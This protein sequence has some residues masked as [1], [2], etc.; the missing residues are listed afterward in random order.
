ML[1]RFALRVAGGTVLGLAVVAA[2]VGLVSVFDGNAAPPGELL[3]QVLVLSPLITTLA[4][5]LGV[6]GLR[7]RG[8]LVV[9]AL[10][11]RHPA[12]WSVAAGLGAVLVVAVLTGLQV[13]VPTAENAAVQVAVEADA[14]W[15]RSA[16]GQQVVRLGVQPAWTDAGE[17]RFGEPPSQEPHWRPLRTAA[18]PGDSLVTLLWGTGSP[19]RLAW[20]LL[21]GMLPLLAGGSALLGALAETMAVRGRSLG[22]LAAAGTI[23]L[24]VVAATVLGARGMLPVGV[25]L[26]PAALLAPCCAVLWRRDARYSATM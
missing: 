18:G 2:V 5:G 22:A 26:V 9:L 15:W 11:G 25:A 23:W 4:A 10:S 16:D 24:L 8:E 3:G 7:V 6:A 19:D 1:A 12:G 17:V 20:G 21:M 13:A 14:V